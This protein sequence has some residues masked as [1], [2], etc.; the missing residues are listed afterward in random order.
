M[1]QLLYSKTLIS[2]L[3]TLEKQAKSFLAHVGYPCRIT[4][5]AFEHPSKLGYFDPN[6]FEIGLNKLLL[7]SPQAEEVLKHEL[8]HLI[9]YLKTG[10]LDHGSQFKLTCQD[11]GL[12]EEMGKATSHL[13]QY[14][15]VEKLFRLAEKGSLHE[16][17]SALLKAQELIHKYQLETLPSSDEE[18]FI[19]CRSLSVPR[20]SP[21][22][23]A[24]A[25][26]LRT[27]G[28][29]PVMNHIKSGV[30]LELFGSPLN[31]TIADH[32]AAFLYLELEHLYE[33]A[34]AKYHL[35][36]NAGRNSFFRGVASGFVSKMTKE[37][38]L[39]VAPPVSIAYPHL[40]QR[41]SRVIECPQGKKI[42]Q[43]VGKNLSLRS[44]VSTSSPKQ[45]TH[46]H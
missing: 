17:E 13:K 37:R 4:L 12:S 44:G 2:F 34:K 45:I 18:E 39:M 42:G 21:K 23:N 28:V 10:N 35:E 22:L 41:K 43:T 38:G 40:S 1:R 5:V 29:S 25:T 11:L 33:E 15:K 9:S 16:A 3:R 27:L 46:A 7:F 24:I 31:V 20:G 32:A 19:V 26:I 6:Y 36:G 30:V 14:E 8:A